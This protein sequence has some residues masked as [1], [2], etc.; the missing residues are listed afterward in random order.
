MFEFPIALSSK[1]V[2]NSRK[3]RYQYVNNL[4]Q[5]YNKIEGITPNGLPTPENSAA[6]S[7]ENECALER[8]RNRIRRRLKSIAGESYSDFESD[9]ELNDA[10]GEALED[11]EEENQERSYFKKYEKPQESF[12]KWQTDAK[13]RA[14][15]RRTK[16]SFTKY[17]RMCKS[18]K[19]KMANALELASRRSRIY[20]QTVSEGFEMV[21]P[22]D[23]KP[24]TYQMKHISVLN[25]L[26]HVQLCRGNWDAAYNCFALLI[27]IPGV[28]IRNVWGI[29]NQVLHAK[30]S[31]KYLEFLE[32]M[33]NIYSSRT[34]YPEDV[35]FR[36]APVFTKGS[37]THVPKFVSTWLWESL[38][39]YTRES[40]EI[41]GDSERDT[42]KLQ[43][44]IDKISEMIL[45]PPHMED[46]E[47]W[48][49]YSLCH[50]VK[51]DILSTRFDGHLVGSARDIASNQV[52]QHIQ[53]TKSCLQTCIA[54]GDFAYPKRHIERQLETFEKRLHIDDTDSK[55]MEQ[56]A[57]EMNEELD[58]QS[59][60]SE[61]ASQGYLSG[62]SSS[63]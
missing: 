9:E 2:R 37:R 51:A 17:Q 52:I 22:I 36:T 11:D 16:I 5:K 18:A 32:W 40:F 12:E 34:T 44:L 10:A 8:K 25:S 45:A 19:R 4:Y 15:I 62:H 24:E 3:L 7:S 26:L 42:D 50:M 20:L 41:S 14:P 1:R 30:E 58:T 59:I 13:K 27:R 47:I 35:N 43:E 39:Q 23:V 56:Y 38:I 33:S 28:D 29:G 61:N 48:F 63:T 49:I 55:S 31:P 53:R 21:E 6:E 54:K 60:L 57:E 46:S